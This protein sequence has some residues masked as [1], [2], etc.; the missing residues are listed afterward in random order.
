M[1]ELYCQ[2]NDWQLIPFSIENKETLQHF[3]PNQIVRVQVYGTRKQRSVMQNRWIHAIF[4]IVAENTED[5]N[6]NTQ[7]KVKQQV[8]IK[9][10]FVDFDRVVVSEGV[11]YV[12]Y[13]SFAFDKMEQ[14]EADRIYNEAKQICA[15]FM[16]VDPVNLEAKAKEEK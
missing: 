4:R 12:T 8:K 15:D 1:K 10:R 3:K 7:E 6:W 2:I 5:V 11:A 16:G 14:Q 13:R 9:M